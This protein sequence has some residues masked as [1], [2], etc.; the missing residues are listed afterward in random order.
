MPVTRTRGA[1]SITLGTRNRPRSTAG[2]LRW[3]ASRWSGSLAM[4][5]RRRRAM[6]W[7]AAT[8][9]DSGLTPEVSTACIFSTMPKKSLSW[10]SMRSLSA[11]ESSS[12]ARFAMRAMSCAFSAIGILKGATGCKPVFQAPAVQVIHRGY[13]IISALPQDPLRAGHCAKSQPH[14]DSLTFIPAMA[15][16]RACRA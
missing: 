11:E 9:C 14:P 2:A 8:G 13:G 6:S 3:L 16:R 7:M 1:Y 10:P 4:S 15:G 5:S 12:R